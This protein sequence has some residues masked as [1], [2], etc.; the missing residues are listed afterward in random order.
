[1]YHKT[2]ILDAPLGRSPDHLYQIFVP[3]NRWKFWNI[4]IQYNLSM[5]PLGLT[6]EILEYTH[7]TYC[8]LH[9]VS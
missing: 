3:H 8:C 2:K 4:P 1:M 9:W 7:T 6:M 5:S